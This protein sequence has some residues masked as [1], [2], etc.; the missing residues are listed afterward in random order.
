[1]K[2]ISIVSCCY[3][4]VELIDEF[5]AQ[6]INE[7]KVYDNKYEYEIIVID[8]NSNDGTIE[9]LR[10]IAKKN[11]AFKVI[12]C[13]KNFRSER[14]VKHALKQATGDVIIHLSSDLEQP[15]SLIHDFL[16]KWEGGS[17]IV[18]GQ[19]ITSDESRFLK[20]LKKYYWKILIFLSDE[21]MPI[22]TEG[23]MFDKSVKNELVNIYDPNAF[24]RGTTFELFHK[25][26][27][28]KFKK[29]VR[30]KGYSKSNLN[31][32]FSYGTETIFKMSLKPLRLIIMIG[33]IMSFFSFLT[34]IFYLFY[35]L[36]YWSTFSVG[37]APLIIG[38]FFI[39]SLMITMIGVLGQYVIILVSYAKNLPNVVEEERINFK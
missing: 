30:K 34:A 2:K 8:N 18:F 31:Y 4:E 21:N 3:N 7:L 25:Y 19:K 23:F 11:K 15:T 20:I 32:L 35:K 27:L 37:I 26:D 10:E 33:F 9:R 14:T 22:N 28:V 16:K 5:S 24:L 39:L 1:M 12:I 38:L 29:E 6:V 17:K 13:T 36:I